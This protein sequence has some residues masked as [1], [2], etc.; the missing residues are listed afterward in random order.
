[1]FYRKFDT[2]QM[3]LYPTAERLQQDIVEAWERSDKDALFYVLLDEVQD[4]EGWER[5]VRRLH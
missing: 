2:L 1:M 3:P 4:V 5:V